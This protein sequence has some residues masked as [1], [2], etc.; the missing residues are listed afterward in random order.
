MEINDFSLK[1]PP[2]PFILRPIKKRLILRLNQKNVENR[3]LNGILKLK[4]GVHPYPHAFVGS[5]ALVIP[6]K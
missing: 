5:F 4:A 3:R 1:Y 6:V 2:N